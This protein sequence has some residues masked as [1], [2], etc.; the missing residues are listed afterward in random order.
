[1]DYRHR[2]RNRS[3]DMA[4]RHLWMNEP[5]K[6]DVSV[7]FVCLLL[8]AA[9]SFLV[10]PAVGSSPLGEFMR[11]HFNDCVGG[12]GFV[13]YTNILFDLIKPKYR[14]KNPLIIISYIFVCGLCWEY[15]CPLFVKPNVADWWDMVAY[16][17]G[18]A[19]YWCILEI[20]GQLKIRGNDRI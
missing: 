13:A 18:A 7:L 1:M 20:Y 5:L 6:L 12:L 10:K 15:V 11:N 8:F 14:L 19:V 2:S 9:N 17:V 4:L 16:V 3:W